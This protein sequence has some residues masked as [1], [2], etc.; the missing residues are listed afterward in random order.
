[1]TDFIQ[2]VLAALA[3]TILILIAFGK[4]VWNAVDSYLETKAANYATKQDVELITK[5]TEEVQ[6]V[7]KKDLEKFNADLKFKYKLYEDQYANLYT[8]LYQL[9]CRSESLRYS[10]VRQNMPANFDEVPIVELITGESSR[11]TQVI[12][13]LVNDN[14][15]RATPELIKIVNLLDILEHIRDLG[16]S[17]EEDMKLEQELKKNLVKTILKDCHWLRTQ[18]QLPCCDGEIDRLTTDSFLVEAFVES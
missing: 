6:A 4:K 12:L 7:F 2:I 9:I 14:R 15:A 16:Q 8:E 10:L 3:T 18:L 11:T 17:T 5:K 1:M 13:K